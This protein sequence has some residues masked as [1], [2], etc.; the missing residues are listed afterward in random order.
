MT[1]VNVR[2]LVYFIGSFFLHFPSTSTGGSLQS[3]ASWMQGISDAMMYRFEGLGYGIWRNFEKNSPLYSSKYLDIP[4]REA[5]GELRLDVK[6]AQDKIYLVFK[7]RLRGQ[8][9]SWEEDLMIE[10]D[11]ANSKLFVQEWMA[12]FELI[13]RGFISYGRENIQWGP[14]YLTSPSNPFIRDNGKNNPFYEVPGLGYAQISWSPSSNWGYHAIAN[15]SKGALT[16]PLEFRDVYAGKLDYFG[17]G[18]YG[19]LVLSQREDGPVVL[20]GYF[21][22]TLTDAML[23]HAEGN[24]DDEGEGQ[25][26]VGGSYTF[27]DGSTIVLEYYHNGKGCDNFSYKICIRQADNELPGELLGKG[28]YAFF[29]YYNGEFFVRPLELTLRGTIGTDDS[30]GFFTAVLD[31]DLSDNV[32]MFSVLNWYTGGNEDELSSILDYSIMAGVRLS[33]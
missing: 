32:E 1:A 16:G 14:A 15:L 25:V 4:I 21:G 22:L 27:G 18:H 8:W 29:Q 31:Y 13:P 3:D 28:N 12:R 26:L 5:V 6:Y 17:F 19:S 20:G 23:L 10:K 11:D 24:L 30:S 33:Y 7:P 9:E 2:Q